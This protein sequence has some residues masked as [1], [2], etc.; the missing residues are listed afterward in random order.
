MNRQQALEAIRKL[1]T[2]N[3]RTRG[4]DSGWPIVHGPEDFSPALMR[5]GCVILG[6]YYSLPARA[7]NALL[8]VGA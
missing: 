1:E 4:V 5:R 8:K 3:S 7:R 2:T 6:P